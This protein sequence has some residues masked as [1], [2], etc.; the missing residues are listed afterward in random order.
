MNYHLY[1]TAPCKN[2]QGTAPVVSGLF[3]NCLCLTLVQNFPDCC[4]V[5][6][7]ACG[8]LPAE[9]TDDTDRIPGG[10]PVYRMFTQESRGTFICCFLLS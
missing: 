5:Y 4:L 2:T 10:R 6:Q 7:L 3:A 9:Y 8:L 1:L